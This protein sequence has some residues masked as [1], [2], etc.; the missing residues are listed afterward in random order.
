M[1]SSPEYPRL[2]EAGASAFSVEFGDS[3]S[4]D[5]NERANALA[6]LLGR[7]PPDGFREAIPTYRSV[8]VLHDPGADP[9]VLREQTLTLAA[10]T[11][12]QPPAPPRHLELPCVY[13]G[14]DLEEIAGLAGVSPEELI[15]IHSGREYRVFVLGFTPGFPYL[16]M[17]DPRLD[18]PRRSTPRVRVPAGSVALARAQTGVYPW[19]TPGGWHLLG[20]TDP[21]LLFDVAKSPPSALAVGDRVRFRPVDALPAPAGFAAGRSSAPAGT[22]SE[23]PS[24]APA[25]AEVEKGGLLTTVQD[26]GR[27]G[28]LRHGVPRAG[29]ADP[30][31]LAGANRA[32]GNREGAAGLECTLLGPQL[33]FSREALLALGGADFGAQ[34]ELPEGVRWRVPVG[35]SF[36][37]PAGSRLRFAGPPSGARAYLAVAGGLLVPPVLGS[38]STYRTSGFGGVEGRA[39]RPGDRLCAGD[40]G[41]E[42]RENR[43]EPEARRAPSG[44]V[45]L[46]LS[47]GPQDDCFTE[48]CLA[49]LE[50][51]EWTVSNDSDRMGV[52]LRG[53]LLD[54]RPGRKEI[55]SDANPP[56]AVQVPPG[57]LPIVMGADQGTTGGYP[58]VGC[59]VAPDLARLAQALPGSSVRFRVVSSREAREITLSEPV[60]AGE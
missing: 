41:S 38:A 55:V 21:A 49:S 31:S 24:G 48:D 7:E 52:R 40:P 54:H 1:P 57:G 34:L 18:L 37:A 36:V 20:H 53:P 17:T 5:L 10:K 26:L 56:G 28:Y 47:L 23:A 51:L 30:R 46:R 13:D 50:D 29:A 8:L 9:E 25:F 43:Y 6:G 4:E 12:G 14:E 2:R 19:V 33:R 59:V 42:A 35:T 3:I 32:V 58:K 22:P 45:T 16:G 27:R 15:G 60:A 11:E 44:S 39:L